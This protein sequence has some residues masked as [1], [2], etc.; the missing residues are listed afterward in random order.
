MSRNRPSWVRQDQPAPDDFCEEVLNQAA[1]IE[2]IDAQVGSPNEGRL[3]PESRDAKVQF[4]EPY[5]HHP[6]REFIWWQAQN[7]NGQFFGFDLSYI[8]TFQVT[9][10]KKGMFY[11][12]HVDVWWN[13][14]DETAVYDRKLSGSLLLN[15]PS[16]FEGGDLIIEGEK[17]EMPSRGSMVF[18]SSLTG[19]EVSPVTRGVRRSLVF[20]VMGPR[21]R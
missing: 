10:Y 18:F 17:V 8:E 11:G 4:L 7:V 6:I 1:R 2:P 15:D 20:W 21:W 3:D 5:S 9:T 19:H 16:Q 12:P 13:T 14:T